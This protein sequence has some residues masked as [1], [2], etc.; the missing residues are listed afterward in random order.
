MKIEKSKKQTFLETC[1]WKQCKSQ[2]LLNYLWSQKLLPWNG[3]MHLWYW[4]REFLGCSRL[5]KKNCKWQKPKQLWCS[6]TSSFFLWPW[7]WL[8]YPLS[9]PASFFLTRNRIEKLIWNLKY[10]HY[11]KMVSLFTSRYTLWT[12]LTGKKTWKPTKDL[13]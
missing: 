7:F 4:N 2:Y 13:L 9:Y 6:S 11:I 12:H 8:S 5:N 3:C 1:Y 10:F